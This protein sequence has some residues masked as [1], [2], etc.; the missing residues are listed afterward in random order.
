MAGYLYSTCGWH[1]FAALSPGQQRE[2]SLRAGIM[3][4]SSLAALQIT[5]DV[6]TQDL[7]PTLLHSTLVA[8][9]NSVVAAMRT[10]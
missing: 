5:R 10:Y 3:K 8:I 1:K 2:R 6:R 7:P 9:G 4:T